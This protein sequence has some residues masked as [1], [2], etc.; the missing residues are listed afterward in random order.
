MKKIVCLILAAVMV[1]ALAACGST[2]S[3][4][5]L[6]KGSLIVATSPDFAPMEFT[7]TSKTGQDQYVGFD[8]M[9]AK[10]IASELGLELEI[11]PMS[12]DACLAAVQSGKVDMSLS[13]FSWK[14]DRA[15][16]FELT[17]YYQASADQETEQ[18]VIVT[19]E[20]AGKFT[21]AA[22]FEG[23]TIAVQA[24]SLQLELAETQLPG[25]V[26]KQFTDIGTEVEALRNGNVD[27][28]AV[29]KGNGD[30]I[31]ANNENIAFSGFEFEVDAKYKDNVGLIKKGNTELL[32]DVNAVLFDPKAW[33]AKAKAAGL[34]AGWYAEAQALAG[35]DTAAQAAYD[36][37]GNFIEN[38][39]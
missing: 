31:I 24:A 38:I 21:S 17:D 39:D 9:L 3:G 30:A 25:A 19:A 22:D 14:E 36:D 26:I 2:N 33:A 1:L 7:D 13:G 4:K 23:L 8:I 27:G 28:V 35:I 12:F 37:E 34:Y 10:Y 16:N 29:A 5:L 18:V 6:K 11:K 32:A 20:N 15:Q